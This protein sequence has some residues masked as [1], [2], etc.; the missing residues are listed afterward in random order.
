MSHMILRCLPAVV[1]CLCAQLP[2]P[3]A[4]DPI[5][6]AA[7]NESGQDAF[8]KFERKI[9]GFLPGNRDAKGAAIAAAKVFNPVQEDYQ[10]NGNP[11]N[12]AEKAVLQGLMPLA[13]ATAVDGVFARNTAQKKFADAA[14]TATAPVAGANP[15]FTEVAK[16]PSLTSETAGLLN[17][18][19]LESAG[20]I[21]KQEF[22]KNPGVQYVTRD[23]VYGVVKPDKVP[24]PAAAAFTVNRDPFAADWDPLASRGVTVD[25]SQVGFSLQTA[26][27]A[28]AAVLANTDAAYSNGTVDIGLPQT[29]ALPLYDLLLPFVSID[30]ASPILDIGAFVFDVFGNEVFDSLGNVGVAAVTAGLLSHIGLTSTNTIGFTAPYS[31]SVMVPGD[32]AQSVLYFRAVSAAAVVAEAIPEPGSLSLLLLGFLLLSV[33]QRSGRAPTQGLCSPSSKA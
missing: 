9:E 8:K 11:A 13:Q 1:L 17:S 23:Q 12:N 7:A 21:A 16:N 31:F 33:L 20:A 25:L 6:M 29:D 22:D 32:S 24:S 5:S 28:I 26:G 30:G 15:A 3:A 19:A 2:L 10:V 4:A 27:S 18:K 14:K